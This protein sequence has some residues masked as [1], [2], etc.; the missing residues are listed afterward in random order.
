MSELSRLAGD[1]GVSERTLRRATTGG[2]VRGSVGRAGRLDLNAEE[3]AYLITHWPLLAALRQALRTEPSVRLAILYG[4]CARG[5]DDPESD[6]DLAVSLRGKTNWRLSLRLRRRL[7]DKLDRSVDLAHLDG[8]EA[9]SP[10]FLLQV[11]NEGRVLVDRDGQWPG[12]KA[13]R[14][15]IAPR[16]EREFQDLSRWATDALRK[17]TGGN[18]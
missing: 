3:R 6:A 7:T 12:L 11:L 13:R 4:S 9:R 14:S 5:D 10:W 1:L 16:A 15:K 17:L 18:D 2:L 8:L